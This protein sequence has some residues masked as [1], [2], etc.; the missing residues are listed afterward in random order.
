MA[1]FEITLGPKGQIDIP[2]EFRD[3]LN[4]NSNS[5]IR[6]YIENERII[7]EPVK[8]EDEFQDMVMYCLKRDNK[9]INEDTIKEYEI[10]VQNSIERIFAEAREEVARGEYIT[11]E[12]L[13]KEINEEKKKVRAGW[14]EAFA[15]I[16]ADGKS[17]DEI[18][19]CLDTHLI[20][21]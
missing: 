7:I 14:V 3:E 11:L 8:F 9:S 10:R 21:E 2:K 16:K 6:L 12:Q 4:L 19:E 17:N 15:K 1:K 18:L 13:E 5:K 20:D